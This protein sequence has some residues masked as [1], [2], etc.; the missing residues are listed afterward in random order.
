[1][2][3]HMEIPVTRMRSLNLDVDLL[4]FLQVNMPCHPKEELTLLEKYFL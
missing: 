3:A 2:A 4:P 1:M